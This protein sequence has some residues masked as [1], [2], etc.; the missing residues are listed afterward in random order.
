[1]QNSGASLFSRASLVG[2]S[3]ILI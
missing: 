3:V 1:L 2:S